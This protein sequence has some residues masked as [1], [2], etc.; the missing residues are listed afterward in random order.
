[1][2]DWRSLSFEEAEAF[3]E[4]QYWESLNAAAK[5]GGMS[6]RDLD[7]S[8]SDFSPALQVELKAM[9]EAPPGN[10]EKWPEWGQYPSMKVKPEFSGENHPLG[11]DPLESLK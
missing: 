4:K 9:A 1:M 8:L 6:F 2:V 5:R 11:F 7:V 3:F 10:F